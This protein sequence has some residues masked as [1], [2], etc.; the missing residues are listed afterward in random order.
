MRRNFWSI[1]IA[2]ALA[3][4][5][6]I[7]R[8]PSPAR[9]QETRPNILV[10]MTDDQRV[11][12]T[13]RV[14]PET[15]RYFNSGLSFANTFAT[16]PLCC[17]SRASIFTGQYMHNHQ[18]SSNRRKHARLLDHTTTLQYYLQQSGYRTGIFG[19]YLNGWDVV[20]PPPYFNEYA[21]TKHGYYFSRFGLG[22]DGQHRVEDIT[23]YSTDFLARKAEGFLE[24]SETVDEIP[25]LMYVTPYAPHDPA[26]PARRHTGTP[27]PELRLNQAM[28]EED[29]SDKP[30][31]YQEAAASFDWLLVERRR[32]RQL[33]SLMAVDELI[34]RLTSALEQAG[35]DNTLVFFMSDNGYLWGEHRLHRKGVPYL[36]SVRI[37]L[38]LRWDGQ[39][40]EG[41]DERLAAN[42]D[43]A[44]T[45]LDAAAVT[46]SHDVDGRSLLEA[47]DRDEVLIEMSPD[48]TRPQ[49]ASVVSDG[50]QYVEYYGGDESVPV[51]REYYDLLVDPW[52]LNNLLADETPMN[53]PNTAALSARLASYRT[54]P[55]ATPCP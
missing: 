32:A 52:Q 21:I 5:A 13:F 14:M 42:I 22:R 12:G 45:A 47:W 2:F 15:R 16:T 36:S 3:I 35:E 41:V 26:I 28:L 23:W 29:L 17:P 25:W 43:I 38:M 27:V 19:K 48:R 24:R 1:F 50:Y 10:I 55:L 20:D 34:S 44:P 40:L 51:F 33:R 9:A 30:P 39:I 54:C 11:G 4:P 18:V 37:P 6:G 49:W 46:P 53:D 31:R 7:A 8:E